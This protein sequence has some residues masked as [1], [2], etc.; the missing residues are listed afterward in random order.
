MD[1]RN[2]NCGLPYDRCYYPHRSRDSLAPVC[3]SFFLQ[4]FFFMFYFRSE[5]QLTI[6]GGGIFPASIR[7]AQFLPHYVSLALDSLAP[8]PTLHLIVSAGCL[9]ESGYKFT[10][11]YDLW[12]TMSSRL[13][14]LR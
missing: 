9:V 10:T 4:S 12:F 14:N 3:G 8:F 13:D 11:N 1:T 5:L 2:E 6:M 7:F